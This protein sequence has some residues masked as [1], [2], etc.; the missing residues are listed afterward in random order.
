LNS[1]NCQRHQQAVASKATTAVPKWHPKS[2]TSASSSEKRV[3]LTSSETGLEERLTK[4]PS[5]KSSQYHS[6]STDVHEMQKKTTG[7]DSVEGFTFSHEQ[8]PDEF[9]R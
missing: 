5:Q 2:K 8:V 1:R 4:P 9:S 7:I 3:S 6:V